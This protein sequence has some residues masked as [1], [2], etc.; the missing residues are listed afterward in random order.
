MR[1]AVYH[2]RGPLG[3]GQRPRRYRVEAASFIARTS[4]AAG[5]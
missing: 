3:L 5:M 1:V 2:Q 4:C